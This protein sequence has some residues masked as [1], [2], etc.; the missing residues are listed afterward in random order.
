PPPDDRLRSGYPYWGVSACRDNTTTVLWGT[1]RLQ[2]FPATDAAMRTSDRSVTETRAVRA[3]QI[4][5]RAWDL[6]VAQAFHEGDQALG[7]QRAVGAAASLDRE[8][9]ETE[10]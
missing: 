9:R 7:L 3:A 8:P 6:A 1:S 5:R 2:A 4:D 10:I